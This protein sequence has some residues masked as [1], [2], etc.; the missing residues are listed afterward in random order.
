MCRPNLRTILFACLLCLSPLLIR[1]QITQM[2]TLYSDTDTLMTTIKLPLYKGERIHQG[3]MHYG[4]S[5]NH[6]ET[7]ELMRA[8]SYNTNK[9]QWVDGKDTITWVSVYMEDPKGKLINRFFVQPTTSGPVE[10]YRLYRLDGSYRPEKLSYHVFHN[11]GRTA[12]ALPKGTSRKRMKRALNEY[13]EPCANLGDLIDQYHKDFIS[14]IEA[15]NDKCSA[16]STIQ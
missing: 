11:S 6:P 2:A 8:A 13:L 15:Y 10:Y 4:V 5:F 1:A 7:M 3:E 9:I 16:S 14:M 12:L